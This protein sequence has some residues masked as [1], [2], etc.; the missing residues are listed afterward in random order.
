MSDYTQIITSHLIVTEKFDNYAVGNQG[1]LYVQDGGSLSN[2]TI[3]D[4]GKMYVLNDCSVFE[5]TILDGGEVYVMPDGYAE[6]TTVEEGGSFKV[7]NNAIAASNTFNGGKVQVNGTAT[8]NVVFGGEMTVFSGSIEGTSIIGGELAILADGLA[9]AT[10]LEEGGIMN[11]TDGIAS[12]N[13]VYTYGTLNVSGGEATDTFIG[14]NASMVVRDGAAIG[15][16]TDGDCTEADSCI[17]VVYGGSLEN[18]AI[19]VN[20]TLT[21]AGGTVSGVTVGSGGAIV[22]SSHEEYDDGGDLVTVRG[23]LVDV[24]VLAGG[25]LSLCDEAT[26]TGGVTLSDGAMLDFI[27]VGRTTDDQSIV[28]DYSLIAN[29]SKATHA[30]IVDAAQAT[31]TYRLADNA[32]TFST[33]VTLRTQEDI[34]GTLSPGDS[35]L[36]EKTG[37]LY[38]LSIGDDGG[39][40]LTVTGNTPLLFSVNEDSERRL[41]SIQIPLDS[42]EL[43]ISNGTSRFEMDISSVVV[44]V[45]NMPEGEYSLSVSGCSNT[46]EH[47]A[48]DG[49]IHHLLSDS[50]Y[51]QDVFFAKADSKWTGKYVARH[52]G[53][54]EAGWE[55]TGMSVSLAGKNRICDIFTGSEAP[56]ALYLT[57]SLDGDALFIDDIY[58]ALPEGEEQ[59]ARISNLNSIYSGAGDDIIDLT[60]KRFRCSGD[61][62]AI[63]GG[64]GNDV[65]WASHGVNR[66]FGDGGDD[67]IVG[68]SGND[69]LVGG[70]GNDTLY[71][72]GGNDIFCFC[73]NWGQDIVN[74]TSSGSVTLWFAEGDL[75]KWDA[76]TKT[77]TDGV[78]SVVVNFDAEVTL[79]FSDNNG[80]ARYTGLLSDGAFSAASSDKI[81]NDAMLA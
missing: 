21:V 27:V 69:V 46:V 68:A 37:A 50:D 71:G 42:S 66:L 11:L 15:V 2:T 47:M 17:I 54:L 45:W 25:T 13:Y 62:I 20:G 80:D 32:G 34:L 35:L 72:E 60:S 26:L 19:N 6:S 74:Q 75:S 73:R 49:G 1:I 29:A 9:S 23:T 44:R 81:F 53:S 59:Q 51:G 39:L 57:D 40:S 70:A 33:S 30:I 48:K 78:N 18:A 10:V 61:G 56:S 14:R 41:L 77:Y 63:Y 55:G 76:S 24:T 7:M 3:L 43:V 31:G 67:S 58:S 65:I 16:E 22:V 36:S 8:D 38:S 28:N 64:D 5:T 52:E 12:E 4:G 79:L